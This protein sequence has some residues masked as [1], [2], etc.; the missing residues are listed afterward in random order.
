LI[1]CGVAAALFAA[2]PVAVA[3][4][5]R[6]A[7]DVLRF[8]AAPGEVNDAWFGLDAD[9]DVLVSDNG[10]APRAGTGCDEADPVA[11]CED[12][13]S[14]AVWLG[15][16]D[17]SATIEDAVDLDV[18]LDAGPG[19]DYVVTGDGDDTVLARDGAADAISC[20]GGDDTV[21]ADPADT[22][23]DDCEDVTTVDPPVT[24]S[25]QAEREPEP[26]GAADESAADASPATTGGTASRAQR[27]RCVAKRSGR[28]V[29]CFVRLRD[30]QV[31]G[32]VEVTLLSGRNVIAR[33]RGRVAGGQA[34]L[35]MRIVR[36]R[37]GGEYRL[38]AA[39]RP[40]GGTRFTRGFRVAAIPGL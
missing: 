12:V 8:T 22:V 3:S 39:V 16:S 7:D 26:L 17:D 30:P 4:D 20:G 36:P 11:W 23:D 15:D 37:P 31:T 21:S 35:R 33:G 27:A 2:T 13:E 19:S 32:R 40:T 9:G 25:S 5:A 1:A 14:L 6:M 29:T 18:R 28:W 24:S 34:R 38:R 10:M